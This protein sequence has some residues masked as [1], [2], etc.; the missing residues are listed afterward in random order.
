MIRKILDDIENQKM[1]IREWLL[2]FLGI[3]FV[4]FL[5]ESLS[6]PTSSGII[7]SDP[8]TLIHYGLFFLS[9]I[10]VTACIIGFITKN[11]EAGGKG[12]LFG[13]PVIWLAPIIDI[14]LSSGLGYKMTYIFDT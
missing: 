3:L 1:T 6:S 13:L 12:N 7:P 8:Y 2:G 11:Y 10:L 9:I 4:R 5:F 14:L